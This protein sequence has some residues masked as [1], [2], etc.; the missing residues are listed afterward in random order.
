M[1]SVAHLEGKRSGRPPG[2]KSTPRWI[3]DATWVER[4]LGD[5]DAKPS[6][7]LAAALLKL[8]RE[9]PDKF[10]AVL[11]LRE[12]PPQTEAPAPPAGGADRGPE[13]R[14]DLI[15]GG[16]KTLVVGHRELR[17]MLAG[18]KPRAR[19]IAPAALD[20]LG[21]WVSDR[22]LHL[23]IRADALPRLQRGQPIPEESAAW[24]GLEIRVRGMDI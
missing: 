12:A 3:K 17:R 21:G 5:P 18:D 9:Q 1:G 16:V 10:V 8:A 15:N 24:E 14:L 7:A 11:A 4:H 13:H 2:S 6:T 20:I 19:L 22:G 23:T